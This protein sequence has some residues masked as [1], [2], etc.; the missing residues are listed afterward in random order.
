MDLPCAGVKLVPGQFVAVVIDLR[1]FLYIMLFT[2]V[3]ATRLN[4]DEILGCLNM[5]LCKQKCGE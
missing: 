2:F 4:W 3:E 1:M 5:C